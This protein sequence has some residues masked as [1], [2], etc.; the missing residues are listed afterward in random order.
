M[1]WLESHGVWAT[2][3]YEQVR[4]V[5]TDWETFVSGAGVGL[6]DLRREGSWRPPSLL[7]H[8]G[9]RLF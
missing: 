2:G 5:L 6:D 7:L 9:Q 4:G 1:A 3:R 8:G